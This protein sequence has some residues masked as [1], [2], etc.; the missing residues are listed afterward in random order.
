MKKK[1]EKK[2]RKKKTDTI[3][4]ERDRMAE[5]QPAQCREDEKHILSYRERKTQRQTDRETG[6][7]RATQLHRHNMDETEQHNCIYTTWTR[8]K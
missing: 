5:K 1:E 7:D 8:L 2:E 4:G 3:R 6:K